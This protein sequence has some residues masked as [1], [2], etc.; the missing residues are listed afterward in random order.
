M[1][2]ISNFDVDIIKMHMDEVKRYPLLSEEEEF[3]LAKLA[4]N[5][6]KEAKDKLLTSNMRFVIKIAA[7]YR[8][9]GLEFE[10]L[11]SEG[12]LG[13]ISAL[14][15]FDVSKGYHFISYAVWWIRQSILKAIVD[16]AHPIRLPANKDAEMRE[17]KKTRAEV[18]PEGTMTEEQELAEVAASLGMTKHHVREMLNISRDMVSLN[19]SLSKDS[20]HTLMDVIVASDYLSPEDEFI[21]NDMKD[22]ITKALETLDEKAARVVSMRYGLEDGSE[23][24]LKEVGEKLNLSR[25]RVRQIEKKAITALRDGK[26]SEYILRSYVA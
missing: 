24:T 7:Q 13:L 23:R 19:S 21:N 9:R 26:K 20:D 17:I 8:N 16:L 6:S 15:H 10:D 11:I 1:T 3:Q 25:E 12:Y 18:N 14:E 22:S 5:G 2:N 4:L